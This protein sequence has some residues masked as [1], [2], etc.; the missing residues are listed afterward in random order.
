MRNSDHKPV[1]GAAWVRQAESKPGTGV[2]RDERL[3][4]PYATT[5]DGSTMALW[6][7]RRPPL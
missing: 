5:V 3:C 7:Q 4:L 2:R 1:V 6:S